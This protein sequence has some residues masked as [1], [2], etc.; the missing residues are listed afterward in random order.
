MKEKTGLALAEEVVK[1]GQ[2]LVKMLSSPY[3]ESILQLPVVDWLRQLMQNQFRVGKT[4][5]QSYS[6]LTQ[7]QCKDHPLITKCETGALPDNI[8]FQL[9][10]N[11][12]GARPASSLPMGAG[13]TC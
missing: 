9:E 11:G 7:E 8:G 10:S 4:I 3:R 1:A 2:L 6:L 5:I 13:L 12:N